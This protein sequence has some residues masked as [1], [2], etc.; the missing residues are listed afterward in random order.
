MV[1]PTRE[2]PVAVLDPKDN[3]MLFANREAALDIYD[4]QYVSELKNG[5]IGVY[6]CTN[7]GQ[8]PK[9]LESLDLP[10]AEISRVRA[11]AISSDAHYAAYSTRTRGAVWN[12][13]TGERE[14]IIRPFE[15]ADFQGHKLLATLFYDKHER[16]QLESQSQQKAAAINTVSKDSGE[17]KPARVLLAIDVKGKFAEQIGIVDDS[18]IEQ[19]GSFI[20]KWADPEGKKATGVELR[21]TRF[22]DSSLA[23]KRTFPKGRP[24]QMSWNPQEDTV[25]FVWYLSRDAG[26]FEVKSDP[27]LQARAKQMKDKDGDLLIEVVKLSSGSTLGKVLIETGKRSFHLHDLSASS[28]RLAVAVNDNRV[29]VYAYD[30]GT[31]VGRVFGDQPVISAQAH[32]LAVRTQLNALAVFNTTTFDKD[33]ESSFSNNLVRVTFLDQGARLLVLTSDQ[34]IHLLENAKQSASVH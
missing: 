31:I 18:V 17:E 7:K 13:Q 12:L 29:L 30:T 11:F 4:E 6:D 32:S 33:F 21:V 23:W 34:Q 19:H 28:D 3:K 10:P 16:K 1:R 20:T 5:L 27:A 15:G 24:D 9:L 8:A 26:K 14:M 22:L 2:Y 25:S